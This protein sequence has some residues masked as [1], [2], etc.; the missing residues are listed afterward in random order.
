MSFGLDMLGYLVPDGR[1]HRLAPLIAGMLQHASVIADAQ[2][3]EHRI[4]GTAADTL[5]KAEEADDL[6]EAKVL[7]SPR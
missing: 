1:A 6:E 2:E 7:L 4:E 5:R 3:G